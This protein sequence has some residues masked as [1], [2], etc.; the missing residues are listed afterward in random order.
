[1]EAFSSLRHSFS[2]VDI[3]NCAM[4]LK[5]DIGPVGISL[6]FTIAVSR[7]WYVPNYKITSMNQL[8]PEWKTTT[9]KLSDLR[10]HYLGK[11]IE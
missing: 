1:M 10:K 4:K 8:H 11:A 5:C 2:E 7:R 6:A 9:F 3:S